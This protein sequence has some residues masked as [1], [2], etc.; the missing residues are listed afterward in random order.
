MARQHYQRLSPADID[1]IWS[2]LA[3]RAF[4]EADRAGTGAADQHGAYLSDPVRRDQT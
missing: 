3:R 4:G 2:A 1:E